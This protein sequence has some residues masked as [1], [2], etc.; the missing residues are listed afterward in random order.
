MASTHKA[1]GNLEKALLIDKETLE[2]RKATLGLDHPDTLN[3]LN[4]LAT[5]YRELDR[6]GEAEPLFRDAVTG[7]RQKLGL[8]HS[9]TQTYLRN[10]ADCYDRLQQP[11][12][13]EPLWR[14]LVTYWKEKAGADSLQY[15]AELH[16][17]GANLLAQNKHTEA[18]SLLRECAAIRELKEQD[19]WG[20]FCTR[21]V[22]GG[23]LLGQ[24][25]YAE[26]EPLLLAGYEGLK[27]VEAV[28][29][30]RDGNLRLREALER[31][32]QFCEATGN[33]DK[34][35]EWRQKLEELKTGIKSP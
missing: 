30:Q 11:E 23:S 27:Q 12:K 9:F 19:A 17:L 35:A 21:S 18:E 31:L 6:P 29:P 13:A 10:L 25:K 3:S 28:T 16:P 2:R 8:D 15:A 32:M 24:Q 20:T 14:E 33:Q 7:A 4:N 5:L 22:L 26:A 34:A 1:A